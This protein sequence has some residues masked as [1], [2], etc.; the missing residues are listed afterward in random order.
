[1]AI[2]TKLYTGDSLDF[3]GG[4]NWKT[5]RHGVGQSNGAGPAIWAVLSTPLLN[6]LQSKGY[7][8]SFMSPISNIITEFTGYAFV[9]DTDLI[10]TNLNCHPV[11]MSLTHY[12]K[13]ILLR[14]EVSKLL[15]EQS[16]RKNFGFSLILNGRAENG[17]IKVLQTAR[18]R[19]MLMI[20]TIKERN[21]IDLK[22]TRLK[23]LLVFTLHLMV[24]QQNKKEKC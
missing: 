11:K 9:D 20:F 16:S 23:K 4:P 8:C 24:T 17:N 7:G 5:P 3:Y 2:T 10:I 21:Y 1:V 18:V 22:F 15:V 6:M 12:R 14:K 19:C 13:P